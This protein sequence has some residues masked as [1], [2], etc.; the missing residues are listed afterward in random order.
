[1]PPEKHA[2]PIKDMILNSIDRKVDEVLSRFIL[3]SRYLHANAPTTESA[4]QL[5]C[6]EAV[7]KEIREHVQKADRQS[8]FECDLDTLTWPQIFPHLQ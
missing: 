6:V 7:C 4:I 2:N 1:M 8:E 5:E 3:E